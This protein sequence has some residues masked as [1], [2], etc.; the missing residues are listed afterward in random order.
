MTDDA[1]FK[2]ALGSLAVNFRVALT[3]EQLSL[4]WHALADLSDAQFQAACSTLLQRAKF[5]PTVAEFRTASE[6]YVP[7]AAVAGLLFDAVCGLSHWTPGGD[8][9]SPTEVSER[10]GPVACA[11]FHAAGGSRAFAQEQGDK[12]LPFLRKRFVEAYADAYAAASRGQD[13]LPSAALAQALPGT[14]VGNLVAAVTHHLLPPGR[15]A[16]RGP[17]Q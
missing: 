12:N 4:Y 2:A 10:Y 14:P 3:P 5:F 11:A 7:V 8:V 16:T 6:P 13:V 15:L 9:W 17:Q 1:A